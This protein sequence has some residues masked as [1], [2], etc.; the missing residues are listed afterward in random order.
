MPAQFANVADRALESLAAQSGMTL[1]DL[2]TEAFQ[3]WSPGHTWFAWCSTTGTTITTG[4]TA[5]VAWN[6]SVTSTTGSLAY[7][8]TSNTAY[9]STGTQ[10]VSWNTAHAEMTGEQQAAVTEAARLR[11]ERRAAQGAEWNIARAGREKASGRAVELLLSLLSDE[12]A[13]TYAGHGWFEVRGSSGRR[14]RVRNRGQSGNVDLMPETGE[15]RE[16]TYC[17][18]PPGNLPDADAH[19]AQMLALVTDDEAFE[20]TANRHYP[21]PDLRA[22]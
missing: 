10:W 4:D 8:Y 11:E 3:G 21:R 7:N 1:L 22:V 18:H 6:A 16:A 13:A 15:V 5:W 20:R 12:Q 14:W 2:K 19:V 9:V 17:A